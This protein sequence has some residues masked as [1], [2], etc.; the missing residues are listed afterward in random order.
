MAMCVYMLY[1]RP[2]NVRPTGGG[3]TGGEH[4]ETIDSVGY[5]GSKG[6]T[7]GA[8][9]DAIKFG[10]ESVGAGRIVGGDFGVP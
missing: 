7:V 9:C 1:Q 3:M 2:G 10:E 4:V 8:D 6:V 5:S